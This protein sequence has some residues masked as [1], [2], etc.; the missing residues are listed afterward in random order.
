MSLDVIAARHRITYG[1][2]TLAVSHCLLL[3]AQVRAGEA[4]I[5][6]ARLAWSLLPALRLA[7]YEAGLAEDAASL[8]ELE[9][10]IASRDAAR[11][12]VGVIRESLDAIGRMR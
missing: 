11:V 12:A 3:A 7:F 8:R 5:E 1:E 2:L 9:E 4:P 10:S 6:A